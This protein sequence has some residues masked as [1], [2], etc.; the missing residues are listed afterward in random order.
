VGPKGQQGFCLCKG[1]GIRR[2]KLF[3]LK[4]RDTGSRKR[5]DGG[6]IIPGLRDDN[7][8]DWLVALAEAGEADFHNHAFSLLCFEYDV[9]RIGEREN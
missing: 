4:G 1:L 8:V 2:D 7:V 5:K 3:A 9:A 6:L